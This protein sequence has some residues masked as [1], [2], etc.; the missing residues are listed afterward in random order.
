MA[1]D[2][3][4]PEKLISAEC[5]HQIRKKCELC[6]LAACASS[7]GCNHTLIGQFDLAVTNG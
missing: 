5:V 3:L 2:A 6:G 4:L 7:P 1:K